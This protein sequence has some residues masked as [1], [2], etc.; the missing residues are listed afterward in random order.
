V[1]RAQAQPAP[2][3]RF[4]AAPVRATTHVELVPTA[5]QLTALRIAKARPQAL[6]L[7][8]AIARLPVSRIDLAAVDRSK[9]P[10]LVSARPALIANLRIFAGPDRYT[11]ST[12]QNG[13]A[14][15]INGTRLSHVAPHTFRMPRTIRTIPLRPLLAPH[16]PG[17]PAPAPAPAPAQDALSNV[18][19]ERTSYGIDVSFMRFGSVYNV[20]MDCGTEE[21]DPEA[22]G[23]A[24]A[25]A[26]APPAPQECTEAKA[27][28]LVGEFEV[29][30]GGE[31]PQ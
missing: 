25:D 29:A 21:S 31:A 17:T 7:R 26:A 14:I 28:S 2:V 3:T 22:I 23:P 10:V 9:V 4:S 6:Q 11:A 5:A 24:P 30:G 13:I 1:A 18:S 16:V 15:E 12:K 8:S 27:L 19:V 20:T